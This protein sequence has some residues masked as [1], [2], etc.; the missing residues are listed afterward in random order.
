MLAWGCLPRWAYY[1]CQLCHH[2]QFVTSLI[3]SESVERGTMTWPW[4]KGCYGRKQPRTFVWNHQVF[5]EGICMLLQTCWELLNCRLVTRIRLV[6]T[7]SVAPV[8]IFQG[9]GG[10]IGRQKSLER[11]QKI[12]FSRE[13]RTCIP[14][15]KAFQCI[16]SIIWYKGSDITKPDIMKQTS[17]GSLRKVEKEGGLPR[18]L[19]IWIMAWQ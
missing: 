18:D 2:G 14:K 13:Q 12:I 7:I 4:V 19:Y 8:R 11:L 6:E 10:C 3:V 1:S 15:C 5:L 16:M 17:I 9:D